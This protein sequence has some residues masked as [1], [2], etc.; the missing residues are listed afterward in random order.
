[1]LVL[2]TLKLFRYYVVETL[3]MNSKSMLMVMDL[4]R[5]SMFSLNRSVNCRFYDAF[6]SIHRGL[7][8]TRSRPEHT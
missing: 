6:V 4:Q 3:L 1:M 5:L 8:N 2:M 7:F